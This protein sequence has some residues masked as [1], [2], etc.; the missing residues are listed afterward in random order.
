MHNSG[1]WAFIRLRLGHPC[2]ATG[3]RREHV[4]CG[5]AL[6]A[7]YLRQMCAGIRWHDQSVAGPATSI[8]HV[9]LHDVLPT[10]CAEAEDDLR[11][12]ARV[13]EG[14]HLAVNRTAWHWYPANVTESGM[15]SECTNLLLVDATV[16]LLNTGVDWLELTLGIAWGPELTVNAAIEVACWC[17]QDHN[18]H[19]VRE[20]HWQIAGPR[21]L[22]DAFAAGIAMLADVLDSGP[23]EPGAWRVRTGL[24]DAPPAG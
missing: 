21:D 6:R 2:H 8:A 1:R 20:G 9:P 3:T 14:H 23:Y 18:M 13:L 16:T 24:P 4:K 12:L 15:A 7:P 19:A 5:P 11:R 22:A 17:A 10:A